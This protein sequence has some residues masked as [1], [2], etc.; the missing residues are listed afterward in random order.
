MD[1]LWKTLLGFPQLDHH[2]STLA[3][4]RPQ[5]PQAL[6]LVFVVFRE[7]RY[8]PKGLNIDLILKVEYLHKI[9]RFAPSVI[10]EYV[11]RKWTDILWIG[12][13][14]LSGIGGRFH[15]NTHSAK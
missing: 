7:R 9:R 8:A 14:E 15:W 13:P 1:K 3:P 6:L 5:A 2:F 10:A 11:T 4:S 12:W